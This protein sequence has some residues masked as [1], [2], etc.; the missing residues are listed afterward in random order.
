MRVLSQSQLCLD[1]TVHTYLENQNKYFNAFDEA[2]QVSK[3]LLDR[4]RKA[5]ANHETLGG[6]DADEYVM[7][8]VSDDCDMDFENARENLMEEVKAKG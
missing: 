6:S 8:E 2:H 5:H 1:K 7:S 3:E 4:H